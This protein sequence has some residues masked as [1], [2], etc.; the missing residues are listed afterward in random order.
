MEAQIHHLQRHCLPRR[1]QQRDALD[2]EIHFRRVF[3]RD[4][5]RSADAE[6]SGNPPTLNLRRR[7]LPLVRRFAE[8]VKSERVSRALRSLWS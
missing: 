6:T 1:V 2:R 8:S 4:D 3:V 7:D 5:E